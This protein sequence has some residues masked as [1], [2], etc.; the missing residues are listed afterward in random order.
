SKRSTARS[1]P[2]TTAAREPRPI[3]STRL[4]ARA[5]ACRASRRWMAA[6]RMRSSKRR[7]RRWDEPSR[8]SAVEPDRGEGVPDPNADLALALR[9]NRLRRAPGRARLGR[10]RGDDEQPGRLRQSG[11]GGS[12]YGQ[13]LFMFLIIFQVAL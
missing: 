11:L 12:S 10:V 7:R 4:P 1:K 6:W 9:D 2:S 5:F 13:Y 8:A 3:S